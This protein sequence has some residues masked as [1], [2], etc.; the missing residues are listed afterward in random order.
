MARLTAAA[1]AQL[2]THNEQSERQPLT[3][4]FF[5]C[6]FFTT[7]YP[8]LLARPSN[9]VPSAIVP[10][11]RGGGGSE[12]KHRHR[13]AVRGGSTVSRGGGRYRVSPTTST[14][15]D[16]R[17]AKCGPRLCCCCCRTT[18]SPRCRLLSVV[19]DFP[20]V[21]FFCHRRRAPSASHRDY[22][23]YPFLQFIIRIVSAVGATPRPNRHLSIFLHVS[24]HSRN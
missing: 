5:F 20:S 16:G 2:H 23:V 13:T 1:A 3:F 15:Y 24:R 21:A 12:G 6:L 8:T 19:L 22:F 11:Y 4:F 18:P 7:T 9:R 17:Y 14:V 10:G